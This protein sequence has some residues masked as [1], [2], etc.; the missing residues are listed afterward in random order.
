M[1]QL[2]D[3]LDMYKLVTGHTDAETVGSVLESCRQYQSVS[4]S[5]STKVQRLITAASSAAVSHSPAERVAGLRVLN[6]ALG[7]M[8]KEMVVS[9]GVALGTRDV[10]A[11][12]TVL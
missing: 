9:C 11:A 4:A 10:T 5:T 1:S 6:M 12:S 3:L 2:L 7:Q 8:G